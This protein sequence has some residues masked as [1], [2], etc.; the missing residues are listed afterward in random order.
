MLLIKEEIERA[1]AQGDLAFTG[2]IRKDSLLL[3]LGSYAQL[4]AEDS[5]LIYPSRLDSLKTMYGD[6]IS[7]WTEIHLRPQQ[8]VL[9]ATAE[10]LKLDARHYA[11]LSTL[12]HIARLGLMAQGGSFV[13]DRY[14][15]GHLT[16]EIYNLSPHTIVL[17]KGMPFAKLSLFECQQIRNGTDKRGCQFPVHY[18]M[19]NQLFSQF[20][21]EFPDPMRKGGDSRD[22]L[23]L[24]M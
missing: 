11:L 6:L 17:Y 5:R 15:D 4:L 3:T 8:F 19:P 24:E 16:L 22:E 12:S 7:T 21:V 10:H 14:Y 18:G 13:V 9:V 1:I 20:P 2:R 23:R